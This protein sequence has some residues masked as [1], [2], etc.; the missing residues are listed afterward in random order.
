MLIKLI[1]WM[2]QV[3]LILSLLSQVSHLLKPWW[4][5]DNSLKSV[6]CIPQKG[7]IYNRANMMENAIF[8]PYN[9]HTMLLLDVTRSTMIYVNLW[10]FSNYLA[11]WSIEPHKLSMFIFCSACTFRNCSSAFKYKF[12]TCGNKIII[13]KVSC[14]VA[15]N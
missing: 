13:I 1:V 15:S 11:H 7:Y 8:S 10:L 14:F 4:Q 12:Y 3:G 2:R 6:P 5:Y 9:Q